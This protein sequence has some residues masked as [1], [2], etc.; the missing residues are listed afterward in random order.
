MFYL[1]WE[2]PI[3]RLAQYSI[4]NVQLSKI[5]KHFRE[6]QRIEDMSS[7]SPID[8]I[9]NQSASNSDIPGWKT[10]NQELA[11]ILTNLRKTEHK[12]HSK[13]R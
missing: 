12:I 4:Y 13:F 3:A 10:A 9:L 5:V 8:D 11:A 1:V 2:N 7:P 6:D